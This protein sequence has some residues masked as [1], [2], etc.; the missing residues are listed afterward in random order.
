MRQYLA[1]GLT[2]AVPF[3]V[4][5]TKPI[6]TESRPNGMTAAT[7]PGRLSICDCTNGNGRRYR[8][9]VWEKNLAEGSILQE[10][11]KRNAAFGLLEHPKDG[12]ITLQSP[13]SHQVTKAEL[14]ETLDALTGKRIWEVLGEI[15]LYNP[16]L[17]PESGKLLGLIQGGY[18]PLVSSR[19]YG[20]LAKGT[21]G[22]DEVQ[23]D[24]V[25]EGWDVVIKPSFERAELTPDR[26]AL[27]QTTAHL[28]AP[29]APNPT[30]ESLS[31][32]YGHGSEKCPKC[33]KDSYAGFKDSEKGRTVTRH[34]SSCGYHS[35]VKAQEDDASSDSK[36]LK[37]SNP[38]LSGGAPVLASVPQQKHSK[39]MELNT[40][41][42][43][44][45]AM[46]SLEPSRL[47]PQRFA[48][49]VAQVEE[50][51]QQIAESC[52]DPKQSWE[53]QKMH[54]ALDRISA[55]LSESMQAPGKQA[56]KLTENNTKLMKVIN[57]VAQTALTY[58]KKLGE[59][60][61]QVGS[62]TKMI[63]ELTRRGQGWQRLAESRK[64]KF[65]QLQED[66]ETSC[67]SL[68]I[69]SKRYHE[70]TT[71][72]A[73]RVI[74]L[75]FA[76]KLT[77][78]LNKRLQ[79]ATRLKHIAAIRETLAP[80]DKSVQEEETSDAEK[81]KGVGDPKDGEAATMVKKDGQGKGSGEK[82]EVVAKEPGN[83]TNESK[84][85]KPAPVTE[86]KN[87]AQTGPKVVLREALDPR[88]LNESVEMVK[89]LSTATA[90]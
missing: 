26:A 56:R 59:S 3:I 15:T 61:K 20:S 25:C 82:G 34:C 35:E 60:L 66:F 30:A 68:D 44:I 41:R 9:P 27:S 7:I 4:D 29:L 47:D 54:T 11:I 83:V 58:K 39:A 64:S 90:K 81:K 71:E 14:V 55:K 16:T 36:N 24:Y 50:L 21:D 23:E 45:T 87:S 52:S 48:E 79:E 80:K 65:A 22:V 85:G 32:A 33:G 70:D 78:E 73:R 37:E 51:H 19:G 31:E 49:S 63:E 89:R 12:I 84:D 72:L 46:E 17:V 18:N 28:A 13:I 5:R 6:V 86:D 88:G 67:E 77:P 1:E 8:K 10:A 42:S 43:R 74:Q 53:A 57:A 40:I 62:H 76:D 69:I 38:S 2:G 75:E